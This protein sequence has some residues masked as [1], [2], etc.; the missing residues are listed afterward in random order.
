MNKKKLKIALVSNTSNFFRVFMLNHIKHLSKKYD[1]FI[2]CNNAKNLKKK[3]PNNVSLI[4]INFKRG[5]SLLNDIISFFLTLFFFLKNKPN[6]SISFTPK[7]GLMV[8]LGSL[9]ARTPN[10]IHWF[11]GQIWASSKGFVKI[12]YKFTDK[13]IFF[14]SHHIFIDGF[15]QRNFLIKEKIISK[16][17]S[18]VFHKG[19]VGGVNVSKFSFDKKKRLKLRKYYS[20]AS[21][22]FVFL[23][24]G[25]INRDKGV[26]ELVNAFKKIEKNKNVLLIFVGTIEDKKLNRLLKNNIKILHFNYTEKPEDWFS[27]ADILCLPSH[28][29]GFGT[30][31]I[32]AASCGIPSLCSNIYG[33]RDAM[34]E[35]KTGFFHEVGNK[36]DIKK[37]MLHIIKNKKLVKKYGNLAKKRVLK[38]F[39]Q[40][41]ITNQFL[42]FI[43]SKV[44]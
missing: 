26:V 15:S 37:K 5:F 41:L 33:L 2:C 8:A 4:D 9:I 31:I 35:H 32:E 21:N 10:R 28:R 29:E 7:I 40:N 6:L 30:T 18:I 16:E 25:R 23:F 38:N 39:E 36:N 42:K 43:N 13:I 3:V 24:L 34:I 19:S 1:L 11:T 27:L 20:I 17:K 14:L 12:F 22:T 44:L